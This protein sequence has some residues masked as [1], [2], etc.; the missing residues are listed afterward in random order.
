M[1]FKKSYGYIKI[2][3]ETSVYYECWCIP[4]K[5]RKYLIITISYYQKNIISYSDY[6]DI[7]IEIKSA[8]GIR[9]N[10]FFERGQ[11]EKPSA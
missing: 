10:I 1:Q 11:N 5:L 7:F 8:L 4:D 3:Q 9:F 2:F 6:I